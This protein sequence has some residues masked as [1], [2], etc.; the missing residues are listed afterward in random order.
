MAG[1]HN[2]HALILLTSNANRP[3]S[4]KN[5]PNAGKMKGK[6]LKTFFHVTMAAGTRPCMKIDSSFFRPLR[7]LAC[8]PSQRMSPVYLNFT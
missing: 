6:D 3:K 2:C 8:A 5:S 1:Y 7:H 4:V